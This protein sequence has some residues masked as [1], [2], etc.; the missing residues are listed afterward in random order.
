MLPAEPVQLTFD[1]L[2]KF[3]PAWSHDGSRIAFVAEEQVT[4]VTLQ[5]IQGTEIRE[6]GH[7]FGGVG[8]FRDYAPAP[9]RAQ[10]AAVSSDRQKF[11]ILNL[12]NGEQQLISAAKYLASPVWSANGDQLAFIQKDQNTSTIRIY[13]LQAKSTD[14]ILALPLHFR[15]LA[16]ASETNKFAIESGIDSTQILLFQQGTDKV[17]EIVPA[18]NR[19]VFPAFSSDGQFLAYISQNRY[20]MAVSVFDDLRQS[21]SQI[22]RDFI[23]AA[24]P[25]WTDSDNKINFS[26]ENFL[27]A[28][29]VDGSDHR[30][31]R[32]RNA[33]PVWVQNQE[34]FL[35]FTSSSR[36]K[37]QIVNVNTLEVND[38]TGVQPPEFGSN[39]SMRD[40]Q[41][42]WSADDSR[43]T[44]TRFDSV[45]DLSRFLDL[46]LFSGKI[47]PAT[48]DSS[49]SANDFNF[50]QFNAEISPDGAKFLHNR[51][52]Q[53]IISDLKS[54]R[55]FNLSKKTS[56][57]FVEPTWFSNGYDLAAINPVENRIKLLE[58]RGGLDSLVITPIDIPG[59]SGT[60]NGE[61]VNIVFSGDH[62]VLGPRFAFGYEEAIYMFYFKGFKI[63]QIIAH[64]S[65]PAFSPDGESLAFVHDNQIKIIRLFHQFQ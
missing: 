31:S 16:W 26:E 17:E 60:V 28:I 38:A 5:N 47:R 15:R 22:S 37:L 10:L 18:A 27:A 54:H 35:K 48:F 25:H 59:F 45:G 41:P 9:H 20:G 33:F 23:I 61:I 13:D 34:A 63:E 4:R 19:P 32:I 14:K 58:L 62:K 50:E 8:G 21:N 7:F 6:M 64:G 56:E 1:H 42:S 39:W 46:D 29:D 24:K 55:Q 11:L 65:Y 3:Q 12:E 36:A 2:D 53:I 57:P 49:L 51:N 40:L 44:F 43:I 52:G 30:R